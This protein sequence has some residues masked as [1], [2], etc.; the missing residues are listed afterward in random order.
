MLVGT[1]VQARGA[2]AQALGGLG[3]LRLQSFGFEGHEGKRVLG[4]AASHRFAERNMTGC[5]TQDG[6]G[7]LEVKRAS[8]SGQHQIIL[9][10]LTL[11]GQFVCHPI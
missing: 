1:P 6:L 9:L 3:V 4:E 7:E 2:L 5:L 10:R 11:R 8:V